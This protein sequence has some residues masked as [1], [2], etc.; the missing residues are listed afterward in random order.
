MLNKYIQV[1]GITIAALLS[2][3]MFA[4][5]ASALDFN[6]SFNNSGIPVSGTIFGLNNNTSNQPA[7]S[8]SLNSPDNV[9]FNTANP[10]SFNVTGG[11][12]TNVNYNS[13]NT[14]G[15]LF[16]N[17]STTAGSFNGF[18]SSGS[19]SGSDLTFSPLVTG[20]GATPVPFGVAPDLGILI[21]AGM[22]GASR[23][24]N[25]IAARKLVNSNQAA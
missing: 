21:L 6:F 3:T 23:L 5:S 4:K 20:G 24:R 22:F 18:G 16:L 19:S 1:A 11:N 12:I 13:S 15:N 8:V 14:S 17:G 2:S 7:S 25:K 9:T 10:N